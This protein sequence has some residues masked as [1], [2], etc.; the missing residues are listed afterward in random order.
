MKCVRCKVKEAESDVT[1]LCYE[2]YE[3]LHPGIHKRMD[4]DL[5]LLRIIGE[6]ASK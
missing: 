5:E 2:C 3:K 4:E 1:K 6:R